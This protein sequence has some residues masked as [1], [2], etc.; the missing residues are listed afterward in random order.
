[1]SL[2]EQT[3]C[4]DLT[5]K[6][7]LELVDENYGATVLPVTAKA[8]DANG[9]R[10]ALEES[11]KEEGYRSAEDF[12]LIMS[13]P[14][15]KAGCWDYYMGRGPRL[16]HLHD[17]AWIRRADYAMASSIRPMLDK[18]IGPLKVVVDFYAGVVYSGYT[19]RR[20]T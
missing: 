10:R 12:F 5:H 18:L 11:A 19:P 20:L 14:E 15:E 9:L 13:I 17:A 1:M 6:Q 16:K 7:Y 4:H 8:I 2:F 3:Q